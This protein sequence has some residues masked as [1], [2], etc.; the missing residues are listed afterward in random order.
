MNSIGQ[1]IISWKPGLTE[2][3]SYKVDKGGHFLWYVSLL[4]KLLILQ[5]ERGTIG[6]G[7]DPQEIVAIL[8]A[9][10]SMEEKSKIDRGIIR[11]RSGEFSGWKLAARLGK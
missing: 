8:A 10:R 4:M 5:Q 7:P 1:V 6:D 11:R 9:I 3:D 2:P